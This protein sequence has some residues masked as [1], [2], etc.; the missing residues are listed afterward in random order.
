MNIGIS[1]TANH[2]ISPVSP[3]ITETIS[4]GDCPGRTGG[5]GGIIGALEI[6]FDG[7]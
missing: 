5:H 7:D 4:D 3:D 1:A 2:Y 6:V